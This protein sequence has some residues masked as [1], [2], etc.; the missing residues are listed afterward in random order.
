MP[1]AARTVWASRRCRLPT[2]STWLPA[3][4]AAIAARSPA[5]PEPMTSTL[6][7]RLRADDSSISFRMLL[8]RLKTGLGPWLRQRALQFGEVLDE[9]GRAS[10]ELEASDLGDAVVT[11]EECHLTET[12]R[13]ARLGGRSTDVGQDVARRLPSL[14]ERDHDHGAERLAA[15]GI[16]DG[17]VIAHAID[18]REA[19]DAAE[20]V[21][22]DSAPGQLDRQVAQQR[23]GPDPD[24]GDDAASLDP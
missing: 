20:G 7:T 16:G 4:V 10:V 2:T 14:A 8:R 22:R 21:A 1:P 15:G 11:A 5:A 6:Q 13:P 19:L 9:R 24:G 12:G 17:R 23:V 3:S 18:A